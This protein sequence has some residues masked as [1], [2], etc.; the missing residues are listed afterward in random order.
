MMMNVCSFNTHGFKSNVCF[1]ENILEK[2]DILFLIEHWMP[3]E[4]KYILSNINSDFE[5]VYDAEFSDVDVR[6]GRPFGG[7]CWFVNKKYKIIDTN[8]YNRYLYTIRVQDVNSG[9]TLELIGVWLPYDDCKSET[10][11]TIQVLFSQLQDLIDGCTVRNWLILG[12]WN[13]DPCRQR[14]ADRR[15]AEFL[16]NNNL[17][18][19][20]YK[21]DQTQSFTYSNVSTSSLIDH[22][23]CDEDHFRCVKECRII[24]SQLNMSDHC[25]IGVVLE[26]VDV[27]GPSISENTAY[28]R[29]PWYDEEFRKEYNRVLDIKMRE[30][31]TVARRMVINDEYLDNF[32]ID[33]NKYMVSSARTAEKNLGSAKKKSIKSEKYH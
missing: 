12:D 3:H 24:D 11:T 18:S 32:L 17:V 21:F 19:C 15:M 14:R 26:V 6:R 27:E 29:F 28:Y 30:L 7:V 5:V 9:Y 23:V 31:L 22:I 2:N 33:L 25:P 8:K 1:I 13:M 10:W 20:A 16:R 4:E